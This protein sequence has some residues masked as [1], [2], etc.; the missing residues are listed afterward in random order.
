MKK[1]SL[2]Y[3]LQGYFH[4]DWMAD[5]YSYERAVKDFLDNE[6]PQKIEEVRQALIELH[7]SELSLD[8]RIIFELGGCIKPSLLNL[9]FKNWLASVI[10]LMS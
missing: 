4:Q 5:Y 9:S 1:D 3:F 10:N 2:K 6:N 8:E 7:S